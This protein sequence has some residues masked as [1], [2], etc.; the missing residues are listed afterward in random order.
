MLS[1]RCVLCTESSAWSL[2]QLLLLDLLHGFYWLY[3]Q[4]P[5][6][7]VFSKMFAVHLA[8]MFAVLVVL[9]FSKVVFR[10]FLVI[11][12]EGLA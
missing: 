6:G 9:V 7:P 10:S 8:L 1:S 3:F 5:T 11:R 12:L 2:N 4:N